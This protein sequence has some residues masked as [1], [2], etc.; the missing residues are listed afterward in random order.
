MHRSQ[1]DPLAAD[2]TA[3]QRVL[4]PVDDAQTSKTDKKIDPQV[5]RKEEL[6]KYGITFDDNY[7]YLQ[8]LK[9]VNKLAV[10]WAQVEPLNNGKNKD[11]PK[12]NLPSSVFASSVE[13]PVGLLNRAVPS[14]GLRLDVDPD[15]VAAMDEDFDFDNP[16]NELEDNFLELANG[17]AIDGTFDEADEDEM[18][19]DDSSGTLGFESDEE[20]DEVGSLNGTQYS[21]R[22]EETK[23][24]FTEYSMSSSVIR[25]NEQLSL[26]DG[27]FENVSVYI[28]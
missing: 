16:D 25:R 6:K 18:D 21:F 8:H 11:A 24:R 15:V 23:S 14:S 27:R 28:I 13:E 1:Q 17:G 9:D 5:Q 4:V 7:D 2:E 12:I 19:S 10:E 22:D 20:R 3:P 26:L